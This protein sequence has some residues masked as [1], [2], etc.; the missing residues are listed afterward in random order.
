MFT[1]AEKFIGDLTVMHTPDDNVVPRVVKD[2]QTVIDCIDQGRKLDFGWSNRDIRYTLEQPAEMSYQVQFGAHQVPSAI[3]M[4]LH[5][6]D[7][8]AL[9]VLRTRRGQVLATAIEVEA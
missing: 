2:L 9:L 8:V 6:T 7:R 1:G 4:R 5:Q 3:T